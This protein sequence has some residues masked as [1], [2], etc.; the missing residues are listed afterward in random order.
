MSKF[1]SRK[2]LEV[3][4]SRTYE[5]REKLKELGCEWDGIARAWIAP[6]GEVKE[7]CYEILEEKEKEAKV[8]RPYFGHQYDIDDFDRLQAMLNDEEVEAP[9]VKAKAI[10]YCPSQEDVQKIC[11]ENA[12]RY[13]RDGI[14]AESAEILA[15]GD[16]N[17]NAIY[18]RLE[19]AGW[20]SRSIS[21][22]QS[23]VEFYRSHPPIPAIDEVQAAAPVHV[24]KE[25]SSDIDGSVSVVADTSGNPTAFKVQFP[26]SMLKVRH[27]KLCKGAK[28]EPNKKCW[29]V[30]V[31]SAAN[32]KRYFG[33][34]QLSP[35]ASE[36]LED[37]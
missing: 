2:E 27:V 21:V 36:L 20:K 30:P 31:E 6:S 11:G 32:V 17:W 10:A 8:I 28:W 1:I 14:C 7:L 23:V 25:L 12:S 4:H 22:V 29:Y 5:M 18:E 16:T 13:W 3:R 34:F 15:S 35:K 19:D 24:A 37:A 33:K 9:E 26:Y